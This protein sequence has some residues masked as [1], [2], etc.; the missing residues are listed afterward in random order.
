VERYRR[1]DAGHLEI[2]YT[3]ED[4]KFLTRPYTFTRT[5]VPANREIRERFC[6][7]RNHLVVK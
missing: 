6:T 3:L 4:S 7:D 5:L 2:Q 1:P